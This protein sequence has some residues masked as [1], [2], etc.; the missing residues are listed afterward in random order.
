MD[1]AYL[2]GGNCYCKVGYRTYHDVHHVHLQLIRNWVRI[3]WRVRIQNQKH[4]KA[5]PNM[6]G[7]GKKPFK[8]LG[9]DRIRIKN[10]I[11]IYVNK[12]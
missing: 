7:S 2:L 1:T 4:M 8:F 10:R 3:Y 12:M 9:L 5:D 11:R 6:N